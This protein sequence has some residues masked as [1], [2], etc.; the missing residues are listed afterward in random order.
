MIVVWRWTLAAGVLLAS[1]LAV[2]IALSGPAHAHAVLLDT[3]PDDGAVLEQPPRQVTLQFNEPVEVPTDGVRI[4]D[5]DAETVDDG[6]VDDGDPTR[7]TVGLP[8][9]LGEGGYVVAWRVISLDSHVV[10]GVVTFTVGDADAVDDDLIAEIADRGEGIGLPAALLRGLTYL[11]TL[12]AAGALAFAWLVARDDADR[13]PARRLALL[14]APLALAATA[15]AIP[16][17]AA[18]VTATSVL[19]AATSPSALVDVLTSSFGT[20]A[21]VRATALAALAFLWWLRLPWP[22]L[23]APAAGGLASF[24]L[25]GHQR[26]V[27]PTW[28]LLSSDAVHLAAGATWLAGL[29]LL[30]AA[31]RRRRTSDTPLDAAHL[32]VRF[33]T[34]ALVT[35]TAVVAS[36]A[37]MTW[38]LIRTPGALLDGRYGW[39]LLGKLAAVGIVLAVAAYNRYRLLPHL[40]RPDGHQDDGRSGPH[41]STR[42]V[43]QRLSTTV[44]AEAALVCVAVLL[45][46]ALVALPPPA[47]TAG[48]GGIY[49]ETVAVDDHLDLDIVVEPAQAGRNTLHFYALEQGRP[50]DR[51]EELTVE[52]TYL[53]QG[54]GPIEID[55]FPAG[56]GHWMSTGD[57][58]AFAGTWELTVVLVEDRFTRHRHTVEFTVAD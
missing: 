49:Q 23:A 53:D 48:A 52:L 20:S 57:D 26:T 12:L 35:A 17:Q 50:S 41:P 43:Q 5:A 38:A 39:T 34:T 2:L 14:A 7:V 32:I 8:D 22:I 1:T 3:D 33:S 46:G 31:L 45:T 25:D 28:L 40:T 16:A 21:I 18:E 6:L 19:A 42:L 58:L 13:E 36:G 47:A 30:T 44:R 54:I 56:P 10:G 24:L 55:P 4:F 29:V 15:A 11:A 9:D 51:A 37:A 27:E